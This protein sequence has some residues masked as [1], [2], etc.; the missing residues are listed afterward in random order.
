MQHFGMMG[1][2]RSFTNNKVFVVTFVLIGVFQLATLR[3]GMIGNEDECLYLAH[4]RNLVLGRSYGDTGFIYTKESANYSPAV[5]PPVF[6]ILLAP[7]YKFSG[8]NPTPYK[9]LLIVILILGLVVIARVYRDRVTQPQALLILVLLGF[10]NFV[11]LQKDEITSDLPFLLATYSLFLLCGT[12]KWESQR[13][14]Y[15]FLQLGV[16]VGLLSY[17]AY[18]I[19]SIGLGLIP[20]IIAFGLIRYRLVP[21]F[22]IV[23]AGLLAALAAVQTL[24]LSSTSDYLRIA[25][26]DPHAP[27]RNL[28]FYLGV[29]SYLWDLGAGAL[30]RLVVFSLAT[31]LLFIGAWKACRE[32]LQLTTVFSLGY[33]LF[34]LFCPFQ[35][36]RY[37]LP[38]LPEYMYLVVRGLS[39]IRHFETSYWPKVGRVLVGVLTSILL[40]TYLGK[41]RASY[42]G[43]SAEALDGPASMELYN[44]VR[45]ST[46]NDA[47]F[48]AWRAKALPLYTGRR[49]AHFPDH[50]DRSSCAKYTTDLGASYVVSSPGNEHQLITFCPGLFGAKPVFSNS[51]YAVYRSVQGVN[52][53]N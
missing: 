9:V 31:L 32:P 36:A 46:P 35:Q 4:A 50:L 38:L 30:P 53:V 51:Q 21:R 48:V 7:I 2:L 10:S 5:Y 16:C 3:P 27:A 20:C 18:G 13:K 15:R 49:S 24:F 40:V 25:T 41:Y 34:L 37:L 22:L 29:A 52:A 45:D 8:L 17:L 19:R 23:A 43:P 6:P 33:G 42:F 12:A 14:G 11:A 26:L 44:F 1:F 28:H 39:E 47:I